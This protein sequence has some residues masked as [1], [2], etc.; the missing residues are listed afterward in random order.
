[1]QLD[2]LKVGNPLL[3]QISE[4]LTFE[5]LAT[6]AVQELISN[7]VETM[8]AVS[9]AGIAAPQVGH[10]LRIAVAEVE[11][12]ERYPEM[13]EL[14]LRIWINPQIQVL[15][16]RPEVL[17][18]EGCLSVPL[19]RGQVRRPGAIRVTS[20]NERG[21]EQVDEFRGYLAA[22]AQHECDHLDGTLFVDRADPKTLCHWDEFQK[23]VPQ[24]ERMLLIS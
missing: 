20:W 9:G 6:D 3:R 24:E 17:M 12:N 22:V 8:R 23:H 16:P 19:L 18:Y 10:L 14:P 4:E 2:I 1:M 11:K 7:M 13:P 15:A 5:Q 21:E